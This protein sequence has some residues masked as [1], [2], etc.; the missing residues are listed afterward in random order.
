MGVIIDSRHAVA[1]GIHGVDLAFDGIAV[2]T[3]GGTKPLD[4]GSKVSTHVAKELDVRTG[5]IV[6]DRTVVSHAEKVNNVLKDFRSRILAA[7]VDLAGFGDEKAVFTGRNVELL[8]GKAN[9]DEGLLGTSEGTKVSSV[10]DLD[11]VGSDL[12]GHGCGILVD[13][14][15]VVN[16]QLNSLDAETFAHQYTRVIGNVSKDV[17]SWRPSAKW[18]N[19]VIPGFAWETFNGRI[20]LFAATREDKMVEMEG[21]ADDDLSHHNMVKIRKIIWKIEKEI[22][23]SCGRNRN[24][25]GLHYQ[26]ERSTFFSGVVKVRNLFCLGHA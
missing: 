1:T 14:V 18:N 22:S 10:V 9:V 15:G 6:G 21:L 11:S 20:N 23:V 5:E 26:I 4:E 2:T 3:R 12:L 13:T 25:I 7:G 8:G 24:G 17:A 16:I 19:A